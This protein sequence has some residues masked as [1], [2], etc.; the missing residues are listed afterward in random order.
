MSVSSAVTLPAQPTSGVVRYVPMGGDGFYSPQAAYHVS[1]HAVTGD[2]SGGN[3][4]LQVVMDDRHCS[5]LSYLTISIIQGTSADAD[6]RLSLASGQT[7]LQAFQGPV[8]AISATVIGQTI[9]KTWNPPAYLIPG[10]PNVGTIE[11][12]AL[13]VDGDVYRIGAL[14]YL[15]DIRAREETPMG[16]LL[17]SRGSGAT[18]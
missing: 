12:R 2:A 15:F 18:D 14:I 6:V 4:T 17:F 7:P 8:V 16:P 5:L 3:A 1:N 9:T 10:G 13:N 11:C